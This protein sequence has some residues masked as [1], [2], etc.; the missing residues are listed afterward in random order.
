MADN[1]TPQQRKIA[2]SRVRGQNTT[3]EKVVRSLLHRFGFRFR[4]NVKSL[5]GTPDI[6]LPKYRTAIFVNG[7]FWH[8]HESCKRATI[9][10]THREFWVRKISSNVSRDKRSIELLQQAGWRVVT[11]W[12]CQL[13]S[14]KESE[15]TV[16]KTA[17]LLIADF[18]QSHAS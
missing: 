12:Q 17:A 14:Q 10:N 11:I 7:C 1:L 2:M 8:G 4:K 9:P 18:N 6:V 15:E 3:P 16:Q 5:P 13:R